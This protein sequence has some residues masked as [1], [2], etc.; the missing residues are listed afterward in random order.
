MDAGQTIDADFLT[1][2]E[3]PPLAVLYQTVVQSVP[4]GTWGV[5]TFD[6][7]IVDTYG[8]HSTS[9][10][11]S[12]YTC[13]YAGWY[14]VGGRAAFDPNSTGS[15]GSRVHINGN[16]IRGAATLGGAGN[17]SGIPYTEHIL[18]LQP[19]DYVEIAGGQNSGGSLSTA[20]ANEA[21]S[22]MYVE[23]IHA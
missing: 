22:Y 21:A 12:R 3:R 4:N 18:Y 14:R 7:E 16:Y 17:L 20:N 19:G 9:S 1:L 13:Q 2:L 11:T 10:N 23:W 6:A 15:R 8:G 5:I